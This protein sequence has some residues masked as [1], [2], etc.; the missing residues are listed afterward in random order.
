MFFPRFL[1]LALPCCVGLLALGGCGGGDQ[2]GPSLKVS[3]EN[4]LK[5]TLPADRVRALVRVSEQQRAAGDVAG[6]STSIEAAAK[7]CAELGDDDPALKADALNSVA[8][9]QAKI[10]LTAAAKNLLKDVRRAAEAIP[11]PASKAKALARLATTYGADLKEPDTGIVYLRGAQAAAQEITDPA[12]QAAAL[13]QVA[14][15][16]HALGDTATADQIVE[17]ALSQARG[18]ADA[19]QQAEA[20]GELAAQLSQMGDAEQARTVLTEAEQAAGKVEDLMRR[21]YAQIYLA[22]KR[23]AIGDTGG[24]FKLLDAA[25]DS[26]DKAPDK[27]LSGP[28]HQEID[29]LR[30]RWTAG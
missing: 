5:L 8:S 12:A 23:K 30:G 2:K 21:A 25:R 26:A 10:G 11:E 7:A 9:A 18:L 20:L 4:A 1:L 28:I 16:A 22:E 14:A 19:R 27:S 24:A 17:T 3:Y 15:A 6:A 13:A 29:R